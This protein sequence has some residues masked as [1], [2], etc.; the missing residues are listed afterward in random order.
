M[1]HVLNECV[2]RTQKHDGI[3]MGEGRDEMGVEGEGRDEM[4]VKEGRDE[5][6]VE[7]KG[8]DG[9]DGFQLGM[10]TIGEM[11]SCSQSIL[12]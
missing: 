12:N 2:H 4:G 3:L 10:N 6:G 8:E 11:L 9:D 1:Q 7:G 5:K